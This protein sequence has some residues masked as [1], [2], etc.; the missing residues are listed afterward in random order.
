MKNYN[1][2]LAVKIIIIALLSFNATA[3]TVKVE[4]ASTQATE[5]LDSCIK[6]KSTSAKVADSIKFQQAISSVPTLF[7]LATMLEVN[8][9][10]DTKPDQSPEVLEAQHTSVMSLREMITLYGVK[11]L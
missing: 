8:I 6:K 10:G 4:A 7:E 2:F 5:T 1:K 3:H 9:G 11:V